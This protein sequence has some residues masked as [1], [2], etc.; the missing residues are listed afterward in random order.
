MK[1][2]IKSLK[3]LIEAAVSVSTAD[4][5][6]IALAT[7]YQ[8]ETVYVLYDAQSYLDLANDDADVSPLV[9]TI[10]GVISVSDPHGQA[11]GA[12]EIEFSAANHG[13]GPLMYDIAM[14]LEGGLMS[15]RDTV[16]NDAKRVWRHY[17]NNRSDVDAKLFDNAKDPKTKTKEDDAFTFDENGRGISD[18]RVDPSNPLNYAYFATNTIDVSSLKRRHEET[19]HA[20]NE[21]SKHGPRMIRRLADMMF[22]RVHP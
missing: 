16:S 2:K 22:D 5:N 11:W 9:D 13:Y 17:K 10:V 3:N 18:D 21:P 4:A 7:F 12:K 19:M 15:D 6:G 8:N 20:L 14:S 1:I